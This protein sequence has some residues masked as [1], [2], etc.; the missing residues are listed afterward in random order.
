[1]IEVRRIG[2]WI[3]SSRGSVRGGF[4]FLMYPSDN[5]QEEGGVGGGAG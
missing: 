2:F 5:T 3:G 4:G 1:L